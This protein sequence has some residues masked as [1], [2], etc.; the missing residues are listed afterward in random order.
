MAVIFIELFMYGCGDGGSSGTGGVIQVD[1]PRSPWQAIKVKNLDA[2]GL[3]SPNVKAFP[4]SEGNV[5][6][7]YFTDNQASH[8]TYDV[9]YLLTNMHQGNVPDEMVTTIDNSSKLDIALDKDNVPVV[10]YR[11]GEIRQC[12]TEQQSD[13][14]FN[15]K[16]NDIWVEY[17]GAIGVVE[18]NPVFTDGLAGTEVSV[19]FDSLGNVHIA[20][21]FLYEGCDSMNYQYPDI[22]YVKKERTFLDNSGTPEEVVE[23]NDYNGPNIQNN[24]GDFSTIVIDAQDNPV[25]FYYAE[26]PDNTQGL[27]VARR[28]GDGTWEKEWIETGCVV[29]GISAGI[30]NTGALGVAYYVTQYTDG[31]DDTNLLKY[32]QEQAT[33]WSVQIVDDTALCGKYPALSF[34]S[35]GFPAIAYYEMKSHSGYDLENLKLARFLGNTWQKGEIVASQGDVGLYNNLWFDMNDKPV[36]VSYTNTEKSIYMFYENNGGS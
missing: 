24:V 30:N 26:L 13:V 4:D 33:S 28:R 14:M 12:G 29:G 1:P 19:A 20:Y 6:I 23:G 9:H 16:E 35:S 3:L 5:H 2:G 7:T 27:R 11:G 17:T 10:V 15:I 18:R 34:D 22:N 31:R 8:N 25:L 21:Q 32:A 36:I